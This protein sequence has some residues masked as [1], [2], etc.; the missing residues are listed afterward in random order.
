MG[1]VG[2]FQR[3]R[4]LRAARKQPD[5]IL[6][7]ERQTFHLA[8]F[9]ECG[10]VYVSGYH[11]ERFRQWI[12][13]RHRL[14]HRTQRPHRRAARL[15]RRDPGE[16]AV[17]L[18]SGKE[19]AGSVRKRQPFWHSDDRQRKSLRRHYERGCGFWFA[20]TLSSLQSLS[21][22]PLLRPSTECFSSIRVVERAAEPGL[23]GLRAASRGQGQLPALRL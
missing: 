11:A 15:P 19:S 1:H 6:V 12:G 20:G 10:L 17:Q 18:Q 4:L 23:A 16:R 9:D 5:A 8:A 7:L 2:V 21:T 3:E 22:A 13:K 14:G